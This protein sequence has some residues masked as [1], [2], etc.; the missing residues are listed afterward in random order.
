VQVY[1]KICRNWYLPENFSVQTLKQKIKDELN[2]QNSNNIII[3]E[4]VHAL[5]FDEI[6]E[7]ADLKIWIQNDDDLRLIRKIIRSPYYQK[8]IDGT[9]E[10]TRDYGGTLTPFPN[11]FKCWVDG[12]KP[13]EKSHVLPTKKY[14]DLVVFSN[15]WEEFDKGVGKVASIINLY[16]E[17]EE[18]FKKELAKEKRGR[19]ES[20]ISELEEQIKDKKI[21][22][23]KLVTEQTTSSQQQAI[24]QQPPK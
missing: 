24:I 15:D 2:K 18:K 21:E 12:D 6:R 7:L 4:G 8:L 1:S 20:E 16:F 9:P 23:S 11:A 14:A 3:V 10:D 19:I 13:G 5:Q 17:D 22:L